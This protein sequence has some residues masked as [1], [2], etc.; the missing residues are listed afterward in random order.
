MQPNQY[1]VLTAKFYDSRGIEV[2]VK[3]NSVLWN[4]FNPE[5]TLEVDV[6]NPW[7]CKLISSSATGTFTITADAQPDLPVTDTWVS[8]T[9]TVVVEPVVYAGVATQGEIFL[10]EGP[11]SVDN[12]STSTEPPVGSPTE[13]TSTGTETSTGTTTVNTSTVVS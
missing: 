5:L 6:A 11:G 10:V 8:A 4:S 9:L 2:P 3:D 1:V 13:S 12:G 7:L